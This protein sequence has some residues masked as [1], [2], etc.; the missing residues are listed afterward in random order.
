MDQAVHPISTGTRLSLGVAAAFAGIYI[1]WGTTYLA[2]TFAIKSLPPFMSGVARF[3]LAGLLMYAWLRARNPRPFAGVSIPMMAL[4]GILLSGIGN[5]FVLVAQQGIPSGIAALI[6]AAVPVLV[7]IFDWAFFSKRAPTK[8]ALLGT[9]V[10][11][12]GVV[13]IVMHTR[14]LSGNAHPLYLLAM[15]VATT[16]W[17]LGTLVQKRSANQATVLN[18]TCGQMLFGA[19]FQLLMSLVTGEWPRFDPAAISLSGVIAIA[20]LV[21]FGS[22]V[23]LNCYLWLLTRVPAPKVATY[24]LV[25]PVVAVFLGAVV[26]GE[27]VTPLA[28]AAAVLVLV[29]VALIVFQDLPLVRSL[30][31]RGRR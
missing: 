7:L 25:N 5:G 13:T 17:S 29:G 9:A 23:G 2:I 11:I 4:S 28:L 12:V 31:A 3:G 15:V 24:A 27:R 26:L 8:Q 19:A 10:A 20:Y 14:S 16:G 6:V 22:I 21:V 18:F 30:T 1:I